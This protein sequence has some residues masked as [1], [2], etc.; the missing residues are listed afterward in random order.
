MRAIL[1]GSLVALTGCLL[2]AQEKSP[3]TPP[4]QMDVRP[5]LLRCQAQ[6]MNVQADVLDGKLLDAQAVKA[7]FELA[8]P[9]LLLDLATFKA[10]EKLK[11]TK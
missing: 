11:D 8:N 6:L 9:T 10:S 5:A 3:P 4:Q 7:R 2:W 1:V